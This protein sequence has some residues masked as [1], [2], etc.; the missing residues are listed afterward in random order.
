MH[1]LEIPSFF[2][3]YGGGF[4][5]DQ[6]KALKGQGH[7]VRILSNIQLS[8]KKGARSFLSLPYTT[9][10][11]M[12]DGILVVRHFQR[13]IPL[14]IR[15]NVNGWVRTVQRM[16]RDYVV[17]YGKPDVIHAHCAKWAGYAAMLISEA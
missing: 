8:M 4:C 14:V 11:E 5:L 3:P 13:G 15:P 16:F 12:M 6:A 17:R 1:I 10:E 7:Q 2:I 9:K